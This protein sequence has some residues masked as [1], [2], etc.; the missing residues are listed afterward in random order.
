MPICKEK[1]T[2]HHNLDFASDDDGSSV[3]RGSISD[4]D[5][6]ADISEENDSDCNDEID[7]DSD[8]DRISAVD[9]FQIISQP[10]SSK[11]ELISRDVNQELNGSLYSTGGSSDEAILEVSDSEFIFPEP[12]IQNLHSDIISENDK[13]AGDSTGNCQ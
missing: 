8:D 7:D 1:S 2:S 13:Y 5:C 4:Q 9:A 11:S 10:E 6:E 12:K 3:G